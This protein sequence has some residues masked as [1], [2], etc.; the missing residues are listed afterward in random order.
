MKHLSLQQLSAF[1]E[2][3]LDCS[4]QVELKQHLT[5]CS[6]C[7]A[8]LNA[9]R[10]EAR[11]LDDVRMAVIAEQKNPF[12]A[13]VDQLV[14]SKLPEI[15]GIRFTPNPKPSHQDA[16][17][18]KDYV[19]T[20]KLGEGSF[21]VVWLAEDLL[22][23]PCAVKVL[24]KRHD[25]NVGEY[26]LHN[27]QAAVKIHHP[28]LVDIRHIGQSDDVWY[29]VME[30]VCETLKERVQKVTAL[31]VNQV[32][33]LAI[34]VLDALH[35][36]HSCARAHRDIKPENIGFTVSGQVK[37]LDLGLMTSASRGEWTTIGTPDYMPY[38]RASNPA[39]D[40][41]YAAGMVLYY[42]ITGLHP[43]QFPACPANLSD[44]PLRKKFI[45]EILE[46]AVSPDPLCRYQSA[47]KFKKMLSDF[48]RN[49]KKSRL[50]RYGH[51]NGV[52]Q[53]KGEIMNAQKINEVVKL[54]ETNK[55][56][57]SARLR[58]ECA[59]LTN[60]HYK[61]GFVGQFQVGKSTL[62][63]TVFLRDD[64]LLK[65][66]IGTCTTA[67]ATEI[68]YGDEKRMEIYPWKTH[69]L[70][71]GATVISGT[72]TAAAIVVNNPSA[73]DISSATTASRQE[74][75]TALAQ[76]TA[77]VKLYCPVKSLKRYTLLDTPGID[78]PDSILLDNTTYRI[79]PEMD[80]AV[81]LVEARMLSQTD[82][83]FLRS[84][85]LDQGISRVMI[86]VSY[87][88]E[89]K[90]LSASSR[91][92]IIDT[93]KAQLANIGRDYI[94]VHMYC[95]DDT[96]EDVLNTPDDIEDYIL[97]FLSKNVAAG[98]EEKACFV[99]K[100]DLQAAMGRIATE[101]A[102]AGKSE[103][104]K[105]AL[106]SK[107]TEQEAEF[108]TKYSSVAENIGEE[109]RR[110]KLR[111]LPKA[112]AEMQN[113]GEKYLLNFDTC[114]DFGAAQT[115]LNR[116]EMLLK[117]DVERIICDLAENV[118]K[119]TTQIIEK[120]GQKLPTFFDFGKATDLELHVEGGMLAQLPSN[121]VMLAD[122]LLTI[123]FVPGGPIAN[124]IERVI[125]SKIP[126][127]KKLVPAQIVKE[128]IISQIKSSVRDEMARIT[129]EL[130]NQLDKT[131][132]TAEHAVGD[133]MK[134]MF[135]SEI[136]VIRKTAEKAMPKTLTAKEQAQ[137]FTVKADL[138]EMIQML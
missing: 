40:D 83:M 64:L 124:I 55:L 17:R 10:E 86:L 133:V 115:L 67:V 38:K 48:V 27:L 26:E 138:E 78:D 89:Q 84:R 123:F 101:I 128:L 66:G 111:I 43:D 72:D 94:P 52:P 77:A 29:Y 100:R 7:R 71:D 42:A 16:P 75:R 79:L 68:V 80:V 39:L 95:F 15:A 53:I 107:I 21:G 12:P 93:I 32:I 51:H 92:N 9:Y 134:K 118:K 62:I 73:A 5:E 11:F 105:K 126:F 47:E 37:I 132:F 103:D 19:L 112:I 28:N 13:A 90:K 130:A 91:Q 122:L 127:L 136:G 129:D 121:V 69:T 1:A 135:D 24:P 102:F 56:E 59:N 81:M 23:N 113:A 44:V 98:R 117:P 85:M 76:N 119:E 58:Q 120:N 57:V 2:N 25:K 131:F 46:K 63:N 108:K 87:K 109:F 114:A 35:A 96:V 104:E 18:I 4:L 99:A 36:C 74:E 65:E 33:E 14:L 137:L 41:L 116:A 106:L 8:K 82:L 20:E 50:Y 88:P 60:P 70:K 110:L 45:T 61:I 125:A 97:D 34:Q 49:D 30:L 3:Q 54:L 31:S 6:L 22:G